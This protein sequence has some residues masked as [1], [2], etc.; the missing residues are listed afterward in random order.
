MEISNDFII[1]TSLLWVILIFGG[2][3]LWIRHKKTTSK[4]K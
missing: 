4:E 3:I 2:L 1:G